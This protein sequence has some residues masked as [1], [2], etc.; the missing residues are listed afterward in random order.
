[1]DPFSPPSYATERAARPPTR[2]SDH[3][4]W[5]RGRPYRG[6]RPADPACCEA[7]YPRPLT[8]ETPPPGSIPLLVSPPSCAVLSIRSD[9]TRVAR[10][11][12]GSAPTGAVS[13]GP[14]PV[15]ECSSGRTGSGVPKILV[16]TESPA[17]GHWAYSGLSM[18]LHDRSLIGP[19]LLDDC[20]S[21][22]IEH[23]IMRLVREWMV[24]GRLPSGTGRRLATLDERSD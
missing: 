16:N 13:S 18:V 17:I 5:V 21:S 14:R 8:L 7:R 19:P 10:C 23:D 22:T 20:R 3:S 12:R 4:E 24:G 2:H 9:A 15:G 1:M 6:A 11:A